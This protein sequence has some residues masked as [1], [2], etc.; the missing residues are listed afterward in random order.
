M[1]G[2][3]SGIRRVQQSGSRPAVINGVLILLASSLPVEGAVWVVV[4]GFKSEDS[5]E[6]SF[7]EEPERHKDSQL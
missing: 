7:M 2:E 4:P 5:K 1:A 6:A 3:S